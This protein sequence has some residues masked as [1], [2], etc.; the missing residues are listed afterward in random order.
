MK[1]NIAVLAFLLMCMLLLAKDSE[2]E[3]WSY[4]STLTPKEEFEI[5]RD[6]YPWVKFELGYDKKEKDW[7]L[8][9]TSYKKTSVFYRCDGLYLPRE[10]IPNRKKFWR[11]IY[12][13]SRTL[14]DPADFSEE[15]KKR[16]K[17]YSSAENRRNGAVSSKFIFDAIYDCKTRA[18]TESH[19][20]SMTLWNYS[21]NMNRQVGLILDKVE[22]RVLELAKMDAEVAEFLKTIGR[23]YG[24]NWRQI[25]DSPT[26]SFHSYGIAVDILPRGWKNKILY[27][28]YEKQKGNKEWMLI[29]LKNRWMPPA[30]VIKAFE[31][32]GFIWG[33]R[34]AIW[35][36]MH[37]EYHP[38]LLLANTRFAGKLS[39]ASEA[40]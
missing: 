6:A 35:D 36:N 22:S 28:G 29:P 5:F 18:S 7:T 40:E 26:K 3:N 31:D 39:P 21:V 16:I 15:Q 1:K 27:W 10:E 12:N 9:V 2:E 13:Y 8:A 32:Y 24:Y 20:R 14:Q 4:F 11:V 25:R 33:G 30:P 37:F 38:E 19:L 17:D 34:W 23:C